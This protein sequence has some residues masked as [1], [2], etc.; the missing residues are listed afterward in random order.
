MYMQEATYTGPTPDGRKFKDPIA[1][2]MSPTTG[3]ALKGPTAAINSAG[4]LPLGRGFGISPVYISIP[5]S[6]A[7]KNSEGL[8]VVKMLDE[9]AGKKGF[10]MLN[11][12]IY[13]VDVLKAAQKEPEKYGDVIVR[14]WGYSARFIDLSPDMQE[15]VMARTIGQ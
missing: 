8:K 10:N 15:H 4:K 5:R 11:L 1:V 9:V 3:R 6:T 2:H 12:T 13:D 14:V 7:P